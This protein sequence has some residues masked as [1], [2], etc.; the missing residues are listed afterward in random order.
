CDMRIDF[1]H[2]IQTNNSEIARIRES[3]E[4]ECIAM[5]I[6]MEYPHMCASHEM[7]EARYKQLDI[8]TE[9][10][11]KEQRVS[12]ELAVDMV[13]GVYNETMD[14]PKGKY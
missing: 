1:I 10:L 3:I 12:S 2:L 4:Q 14:K 9:K 6:F 7:I 11:I 13:V 8:L 5:H